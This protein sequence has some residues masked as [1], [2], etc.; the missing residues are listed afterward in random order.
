MEYNS[1]KWHANSQISRRRRRPWLRWFLLLGLLFLLPIP[2]FDTIRANPAADP[3]GS[4]GGFLPL[5]LGLAFSP[6]ARDTWLTARGRSVYDEFEQHAMFRATT[7]AYATLLAIVMAGLAWI[8]LAGQFGWPAPSTP[9]A[10]WDWSIAL[11]FAGIALPVTYAEWMVPM[12]PPLAPGDD[13]GE[14]L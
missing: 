5:A 14:M 11:L 3:M 9:R 12:P 10:W 6:F 8:W 13:D 1:R 2:V 7:A 4:P